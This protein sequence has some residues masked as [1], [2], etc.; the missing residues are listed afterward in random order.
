MSGNT[1]WQIGAVVAVIAVAV[2]ASVGGN[3]AVAGSDVTVAPTAVKLAITRTSP[4][5]RV[6]LTAT[7]SLAGGGDVPGPVAPGATALHDR[8][9][10][11]AP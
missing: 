10:T 6:K 5:Q 11:S 4:D 2:A 9:L 8:T 3:R 7:V 1:G